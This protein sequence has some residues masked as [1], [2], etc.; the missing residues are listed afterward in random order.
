MRRL[1]PCLSLAVLFACGPQTPPPPTKIGE[2]TT[3]V[4]PPKPAPKDPMSRFRHPGTE[5][6]L[7]RADPQV[8]AAALAGLLQAAE[9]ARAAGDPE[10][11]IRELRKCANKVPQSSRCEALL[12]ILLTVHPNR[13]AEC[14]YYLGEAARSE[15]PELSGPLARELGE[16]LTG[17]SMFAEAAVVF[18]RRLDRG[19]DA[20]TDHHLLATALQGIAGRETEAADALAR[21]F[22]RDPNQ[23]QWLHD[24]AV[25]RGQI[26]G[27]ARRAAALFKE[28]LARAHGGEP[29]IA[30]KVEVRIRELEATADARD[31]P[32]LSASD[33]AREAAG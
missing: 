29:E 18:Q 11:A 16:V 14:R 27:Q 13:R 19:A 21:A 6:P 5:P 4:N 15:D 17:Q 32:P 3:L 7:P 30:A 22:A 8:D 2:K 23:I 20:A 31:E 9:A 1:A 33:G 25:L 24:E 28:Y 26:D 12:G 10:G